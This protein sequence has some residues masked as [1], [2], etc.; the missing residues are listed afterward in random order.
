MDAKLD[1]LSKARNSKSVSHVS[2]CK[3]RLVKS[4]GG[5]GIHT[6]CRDLG[7]SHWL[8]KLQNACHCSQQIKVQTARVVSQS[9][10][11]FVFSSQCC[12]RVLIQQIS[13]RTGL[14]LPLGSCTNLELRYSTCMIYC[15][16]IGRSRSASLSRAKKLAIVG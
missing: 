15:S 2:P 13:S 12:S 14:E 4:F 11:T 16:E 6:F 9:Q 10:V 7:S 1:V 8:R 3:M 5:Q